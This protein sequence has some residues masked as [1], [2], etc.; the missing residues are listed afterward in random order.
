[1][2]SHGDPSRYDGVAPQ[3]PDQRSRIDRRW[4]GRVPDPTSRHETSS[5]REQY[6]YHQ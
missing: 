1:L 3:L 2:H 5:E 6:E 4:L